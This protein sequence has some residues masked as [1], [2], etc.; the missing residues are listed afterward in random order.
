MITRPIM[1]LRLH[2][3]GFT[4]LAEYLDAT[5]PDPWR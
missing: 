1:H 2:T 3:I 4:A 5:F